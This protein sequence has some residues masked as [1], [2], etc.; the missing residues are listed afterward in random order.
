[1]RV[2]DYIADFFYKNGIRSVFLVSG[3]GMMHLLDGLFCNKH[4]EVICTHHEQAAAMAGVGYAKS[5][6]SPAVVYLTTGCGS[7]NAVTGLLDAWQDSVP[8]I[9]ISGQSKRKESVRGSKC[10]LRQFGVQEVD[11]IPIVSSLTKYSV[12]VDDPLK[13]KVYLEKAWQEAVSG[14]PGPVWIDVPLDVQAAQINT[15]DLIPSDIKPYIKATCTDEEIRY[16]ATK[17]KS[18]KRPIIIMGQGV[19]I[20]NAGELLKQFIDMQNIPVV[21]S[22]LGI[23]NIPTDESLYIGRIGNKGDRAGNFA[24]QNADFV[25][26]LGSRLS[27]SSTGHEYNKFARQAE[28]FVVDIDPEEHK[29]NTVRIDRFIYS[30]VGE[31][32]KKM[33]LFNRLGN[34]EQWVEKCVFWRNK[35]NIFL[36]DYRAPD[37]KVNM[38]RFMEVLNEQLPDDALVVSDAGSSFYVVSQ[39][40]KTRNGQRYITSG[41]QADMG[42]GLPAAIG[43]SI[44]RDKGPIIA[45]IGDGSLQMNIQELQTAVHYKLPLK[46]FIWNNDGYL[47]IRSTQNRFFEGRLLGTDKTCGVSFPSL[48]KI[49]SAYGIEYVKINKTSELEK[50]IDL[51]LKSNCAVICEVMCLPEQDLLT[52]SSMKLPD[53]TMVSKPLEDMYPF[54][55]RE[56]LFNEMIADIL[57]ESKL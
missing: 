9:F 43:A 8:V 20:A 49:A 52:V 7:T 19:R 17:I 2:A 12:F 18:S 40:L 39:A 42:F 16:I 41:G 31:F 29:K 13:I 37:E 50:G 46:L 15:E 21:A 45:V 28:V 32:L 1:M 11:I 14:R 47:S 57:D 36:D 33:L 26:V 25:L 22:R 35:F 24:L 44:S 23:D 30:D 34:F 4:L 48:E 10:S 56:V 51:A 5:K 38:Y 3:G 54:L 6:G 55:D 27:V 53:G